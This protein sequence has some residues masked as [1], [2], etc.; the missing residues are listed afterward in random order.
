MDIAN[1]LFSDI[2][3]AVDS[4]KEFLGFVETCLP[5]LSV[6]LIS[7]TGDVI[8]GSQ[9]VDISDEVRKRIL[10]EMTGP[11]GSIITVHCNG[12]RVTA[13]FIRELKAILMALQPARDADD[14]NNLGAAALVD[15]GVQLWLFEKRHEEDQAFIKIRKKQFDRKFSVIEKK[16]QEILEDNYRGHQT[17]QQQQQEY[18]QKLKI[19][20]ARQTAE[21]RQT[22]KSLLHA[23]EA[24][25][26][27]NRA[28]SQFLANMSHEIRTPIN[29]IIGFTDILLDTDLKESQKEYAE[30]IKTSSEILLS[31]INDILD[32]S[33]IEAGE[34]DFEITEFDPELLAF[35]VC[36]LI[37]PKIQSKPVEL[38]CRIG[39]TVP[40]LVK[41]DPLRFRQVLTNLM[42][43]AS[44]FTEAGEIELTVDIEEEAGDRVKLHAQVRDTGIGLPADKIESI[45][46]PFQQADSSTT[47]KYGGTGL[48]LTICRQ[49]ATIMQGDVWAESESD[50]GSTF[51]FTSW[52]GRSVKKKSRPYQPTLLA[53]KKVLIVDD[54]ASN[55]SIVR[56]LLE[57]VGMEAIAIDRGKL[58]I[59]TLV[60]GLKNGNPFDA[61]LL[62]LQMTDLNGLA[63][64][65]QIRTH[66]TVLAT[67]PLIAMSARMAREVAKCEAAGVNGFLSKPIRRQKLYDMLERILTEVF[68]EEKG[69][70]ASHAGV[71]TEY[72]V[73]E[74][75][76][77][78]IRVLL[79][80][81]NAINQK[82]VTLMLTKSGYA[83]EVAH[84]GQEA[85]DKYTAAPDKI[86]LIFMDVQMPEKD[87]LEATQAIRHFEAALPKPLNGDGSPPMGVRVPIVAMTASAMTGDREKCIAAGMDD[88]VPKPIKRE[89]VLEVID[90]YILKRGG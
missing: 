22:N 49:I 62:D 31:L 67:M 57:M 71:K 81:D 6:A 55:L 60:Q 58:A 11:D 59:P 54:S 68:A 72:S 2:A 87:G 56:N 9:R 78:S 77:Q 26:A 88:Y 50:G 16:Y 12:Q 14:E 64:A 63:L 8:S 74:E 18:S 32:S 19:E 75:Q 73:R 82:L 85:L 20:I 23:S 90:K 1:D 70:R 35:D 5:G 80:E 48:G 37:R 34:L 53:G 83:V 39:E 17:I 69:A 13:R 45:F 10:R 3:P 40:P 89:I 44:K 25:E 46:T 84:N 41:G 65:E 66:G 21:L 86:D 52:L 28:K 51:H 38:L 29:G 79:A 15:M 30:T 43:N 61:C 24:A 7:E 27:A 33:K 42:G 47:R 76:K 4:S 36:D